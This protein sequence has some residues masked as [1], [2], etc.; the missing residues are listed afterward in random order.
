MVY[1][2]VKEKNGKRYFYRVLSVRKGSKVEKKRVYLGV[3]LD[4]KNLADKEKQ[5]DKEL[6][7]LSTLLNEK[8][9]KELEA[10]KKEFLIQS[11]ANLENR[12]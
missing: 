10:I 1:T 7:L 8:E 6:M 2:E 5:A 4:K 3:D 11:N 12:Y 9:K